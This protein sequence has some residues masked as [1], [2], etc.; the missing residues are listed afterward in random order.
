MAQTAGVPR[1]V[2]LAGG[3]LMLSGVTHISQLLVYSDRRILIGVTTFG[4]IYLVLGWLL[5]RGSR[6]ALWAAAILP[7]F[8]GAAGIARFLFVQRNPFSVWHVAIDFVV[9]PV[10]VYW[11]AQARSSR[12]V[13][14]KRSRTTPC[15]N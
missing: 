7:T 14:C 4:V 6:S 8:G 2:Q 10:C 15:A 13:G 12:P 9:V 3:L 5:A 11:L 1:S